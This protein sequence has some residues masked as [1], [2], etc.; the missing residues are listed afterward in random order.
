MRGAQLQRERAP[1]HPR[2][3]IAA[4]ARYE[5]ASACFKRLE[6]QA[7]ANSAD[8]AATGL[9]RA[10]SDEFHLRHVRLERLL[11]IK[12]YDAA[13]REVRVLQDFVARR[14]GPYVQWLAAVQRELNTRFASAQQKG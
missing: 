4:V 14:G 12:K 13:Q 6:L 10:L 2:D 1:F 7:D 3:G 9:R 5:E 8:R 11:K